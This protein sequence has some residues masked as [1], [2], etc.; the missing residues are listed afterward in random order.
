MFEDAGGGVG[1]GVCA[2]V[3]VVLDADFGFGVGFGGDVGLGVG[4][5]AAGLGFGSSCVGFWAESPKTDISSNRRKAKR[6][7]G[8]RDILIVLNP[9]KVEFGLERNNKSRM[10]FV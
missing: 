9:Q 10:H 6:S 7:L 1:V 2:A 8:A 5:A 4:V 3:D